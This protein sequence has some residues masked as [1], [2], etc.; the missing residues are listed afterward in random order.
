MTKKHRKKKSIFRSTFYRIYFLLVLVA[1]AGIIAG[2]QYLNGVLADYES[3]QPVY[4]AQDAARLFEQAD[5]ETIFDLDT[6]MAQIA[7][8]DRDFYVESL[9][10]LAEG[11]EVSLNETYSPSADEKHYNISLD[12]EKFANIT[13]VPSGQ[14]TAHGSRLWTLDSLTTLVTIAE[15]EEPEPTP[16]PVY[17]EPEKEMITC[18]I[19][20]PSTFRVTVDGKEMDANNVVSADL[21]M[22]EDG[23][24]PTEI[25]VPTMVQ[26]AFLS[27]DGQPEIRVTDAS[28]QEQ[29]VTRQDDTNW[30]CPLPQSP[31][32]Q[33]T[34]EAA[35][36]QVAQRISSYS[37]K[38]ASQASVLKYCAKNSP[39]RERLKDFD[40][41]WGTPH[42]GATF[43]NV[44]TSDYYMYSDS[45]F[46]C[47]VS[48]DYVATFGKSTVKTYPTTYTLYFIKE[49]G[50]G[51]LYSFTLY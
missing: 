22:V 45:A 16:E 7:P 30:N 50:T 1:I 48:F 47:K 15:P 38:D 2:M 21:P 4:V 18:T 5:Y 14:R 49:G 34:Y 12:G 42:N 39:A 43:E 46:S 29:E 25:E 11:K 19:T 36:V 40:N 32:L 20:A 27:E 17:E 41:T 37:A 28:G 33:E 9:R 44:V 3:A 6:S 26:Y 13:L 35:V 8:E 10:Q 24:L 23:L 51:K 31:E